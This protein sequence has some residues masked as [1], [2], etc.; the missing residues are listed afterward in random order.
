MGLFLA[1]IYFPLKLALYFPYAVPENNATDYAIPF[2]AVPWINANLYAFAVVMIRVNAF[3]LPHAN[4]A[5]IYLVAGLYCMYG[6]C[7]IQN[8][9]VVKIKIHPH[10]IKLSTKQV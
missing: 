5:C 10:L 1:A 6:I 7:K 2:H 4:A 9:K 3:F 8:F